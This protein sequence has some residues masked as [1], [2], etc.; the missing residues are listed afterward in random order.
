LTHFKLLLILQKEEINLFAIAVLTQA[1]ADVR[2]EPEVILK[3][4]LI[5]VASSAAATTSL[6]QSCELC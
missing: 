3:L 2:K 4:C 5:Q 6:F 1:I